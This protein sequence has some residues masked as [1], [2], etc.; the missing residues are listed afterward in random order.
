[1]ELEARLRAFAALARR[2]SFSGAAEELYVSQP[3]VSKHLA[4]LEAEVGKPLVSRGRA[5][6][7]LTPAGE[8]LADYVLRAEALLANARRAL[9]AGA[10][11]ETGTLALAASGI[12]G[13]YLLPD[14]LLDFH[15]RYP[16]VDL[17]FEVST[18]AEALGLVR[19]HQAELG[20]VGGLEP[21]AELDSEPLLDDE[22]VLVGPPALGGR[23]LRP[24]ELE[25]LTWI[26]RAEGSAT[27]AAVET[28][29]WEM[30]LHAVRTLELP[31]WEAVK[32]AVASGG[33]IAAVSRLALDMEVEAGA[34]VVLDVPRW[35]LMRTIALVRARGVPLTPPAERFV[36]LLRERL[37]PAEAGAPPNS[38]LPYALA[39]LV[40]RE[41]ELAEATA[42]LRGGARLLTFTGAGGSGKTRLALETCA[43]LVDDF[44]DGVYL[45]ELAPLRDPDD[46]A[47]AIADVLL[48]PADQLADRLR[49][50]RI[51]LLLDNFEHLLEAAP[52]VSELLEQARSLAVLVTSR[53]PL[54]VKGEREYRVEPLEVDAAAELFLG[55]AR[56]V[57]PR[58][59]DGDAVV[60]ICERLDRL[61]LA[62]ELA[63]ARARGTTASRLAARLE[64]ELPI[65][66]G[67]RDAPARQRT[68][69]G[70]IAWSYDL[71]S[72][73]QQDLLARLS[74]FRGGCSHEAAREVC[75]ADEG[76]LAALDELG[77][78][79]GPADDRVVLLETVREFA[80]A[81]LNEG[82]APDDLSRRHAEHFLAIAR[83]ART[84][85][86]GPR[87]REWL[88]RLTVELDNLRAALDHA[89]GAGD[90]EL[91][92]ALGAALE[93]LWIRGMRQR[94]AVR[95]LQPLL[96]LTGEATP[97][98]RADALVVAGR[99]ALESGDAGR[100]DPW[101]RAGVDLARRENDRT[102]TAWALHGL[103]HLAAEQ[104]SP[105]EARALFEESMELFLELG[106]HAPAGGR[107]TFLAFYAAREGDLE[108]ARSLLERATE[109][110]R[111]A[112]DLA[113]VGGCMHSLGDVELR[114]GD[115]RAALDW[116]REA[117]PLLVST[118]TTFD[119]GYDLAGLAA[120]FALEGRPVEGARLW[121]VVERLDA[122]ADRKIEP[123]D[124]ANYVRAIGDVDQDAFGAGSELS[125]DDAIALAQETAD[126]LAASRRPRLARTSGHS[127]SSTE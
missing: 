16:G 45:V 78:V 26:S 79:Q 88:D 114:A 113:G 25:N 7:P 17:E 2:G 42:L 62:L 60:R 28:A 3:A 41:R 80:A 36:A 84:H 35:R 67:R 39:E 38:N 121:A 81:R 68:L 56:E 94:E 71:L 112:G 87:E 20:V 125:L 43:A 18:S 58:F 70:A 40:G 13:T 117:L 120:V 119:V 6:S 99:S 93:P 19:T 126:D 27:R 89:L 105:D 102:T 46:V 127:S 23:R 96:E 82:V 74:I 22:V 47:A 33:G 51:L 97:A 53:R 11:A 110:Y 106:E 123:D 73:R 90:A 30:G 86:R 9:S 31:S 75:A 54:R 85:A 83:E 115:A 15:E 64:R 12:P 77:L 52:L 104:G 91:G 101:L 10:E 59:G 44:A 95:W 14:I 61:P 98:V 57:N 1:M 66:S 29:R 111:L 103:G 92:L 108:L 8:L 4:A 37:S 122:E 107:M 100:A 24:K 21:P 65:L 116:Y 69:T 55:R 34:L 124:R 50:A 5:G 109:Q 72:E 76:D 118:S 48:V 49:G 63:A 32:R